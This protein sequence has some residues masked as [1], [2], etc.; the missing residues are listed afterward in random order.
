MKNGGNAALKE[1]FEKYDLNGQD[2]RVK[3]VT[4]AALHYRKKLA[5][6]A[7]G[8]EF[9]DECPDVEQGRKGLDGNPIAQLNKD[10]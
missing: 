5:S 6:E 10:Q 3:Y 7:S 8:A 4:Q 2:I 1:H 9:T